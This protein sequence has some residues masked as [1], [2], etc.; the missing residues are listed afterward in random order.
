MPK[1]FPY[2][3]AALVALLLG[4]G[5]VAQM[6]DGDR[7]ILPIDSEGLLEVGG[8]EVD[9]AGKDAEDARFNGWKIA[10]REGFAM[11][12][13]KNKGRPASEAPKLNDA[14]LNSMVSAIV[15]ENEQIGPNRYIATLGVLFDRTRAGAMVG[16]SGGQRRSPP[17]LLVPLTISGGTAT[18]TETRNP[19]QRAWAQFRTSESPIDYV[20]LSGLGVDPLLVN[21]GSLRRPDRRWWRGIADYYQAANVLIAEVTLHRAFP[22]GPAQARFV[23]RA[24]LSREA[25]G[26]FVLTAEDSEGIPAMMAE[27]VRRMDRI[28]TRAYN[29]GDLK[30]DSSFTVRRPPPQKE[31]E[32]PDEVPVTAY[33]VRLVAGDAAALNDGLDQLRSVAG[34]ESVIENSLA[35]G[36]SSSIVVGYRG[37][38]SDLR[39]ALTARGWQVGY[40]GGVLTMSRPGAGGAL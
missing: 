32:E 30:R 4:V 8:I 20:R 5:A 38:A 33:Q 13:A 28:Y 27:G 34:V 21:A 22:G 18:T 26:G 2:L 31:A 14:T 15:V 7:G 40:E 6:E 3:F 17:M 11:L 16:E 9:V 24:G 10:Q 12:W 37:S 25:L 39:S 23:A 35:I 1:T 36:G 19:W 29:R